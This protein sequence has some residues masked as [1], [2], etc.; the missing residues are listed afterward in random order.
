MPL[1][2][3][4]GFPTPTTKNTINE[5]AVTYGIRDFLL[6]LNLL[7]QYPQI[8]T[9]VNGSPK[10][11][12]PVLDTV[13]G[14]GNVLI[15]IGL[16][17]ETNGIV[18]KDLNVIYN[19]FQNDSNF[20]DNLEEI[21]Y[22]PAISNPDFTGAIWPTNS[23]YPT[24]ANPDVEQ[25]GIKGKTESAQYRKDNV[26]KNLYLDSANQIDMADFI[27]LYPLDVSQQLTNYVDTFGGL[28]QGGTTGDQA[29]NVIGSVLN[30]QGVGLGPGGSVI[31]NFDF[32][33]SL[34][35]RVLGAAGFV[36]DTKLGN[37]G[38]QQLSLALAN[39][40]AFNVQ[41]EILGALNIQ[42]NIFSLIKGDGFAGF[43]PNYKITIPKSTGGQILNGITRVLG[44]QIPR[45]YLDDDGS[46]FQSE[47]GDAANIDRANSMI[48]NTGKGQVKALVSNVIANS[49][50]N[51]T[52]N[53]FRSGYAPAYKNNK[54][55]DAI[56]NEDTKVYA[57]YNAGNVNKILGNAGDVIPELNY[58]REAL[59]MNSGFE[60]PDDLFLSTGILINPGYDNRNVNSV[61]FS[62]SSDKGGTVNRL[63]NTSLLGFPNSIPVETNFIGDRKSLL[64]K[65]QKLF[66]SKGMKTL[67]SVK[68]E[69]GYD[70][71]QTQ[72]ANNDGISKGSAVISKQR[73]DLENGVVNSTAADAY[74]NF[75]R[76]W[77][78]IER[79]DSISRLIRNKPLYKDPEA[80]YRFQTKNSVLDGPFVKIAPY[81]NDS[82]ADPK[83]YMFSI[84]NLAWSDNIDDLPPCEQGPGDLIS[85]QRGRVMWFPPYDIQISESNSV[86]WEET[87]FI[88]RGEPIYTY[89]NTKRTGQL[90]FKV[91]VDHPS[92]YN[93]FRGKSIDTGSPDDNYIAS[94]FAGCIDIDK[95]WADKLLKKED[96]D[97]IE[98]E[99]IITPQ[100]R[101]EPPDPDTP[102]TMRIYFPNDI[103]DYVADYEDAKCSDGSNVDYQQN[104]DGFGCGLSAYTADVTQQDVNGNTK[105]WPDRFDYGLNAGRIST[106]DVGTVV[107]GL[108][109]FGYNDPAYGNNM[110]DFLK[111]Y[112]WAVVN[113][114]GYASPQG[115]PSSNTKL[116]DLRAKTLRDILIDQWGTQLGVTK[117]KLEKRF[118]TL[119][120][121]A[122]TK[123]DVPDCPVES[124]ANPNPPVDIL[125]CKLARRVEISVTFDANLKAEYIKALEPLP[126]LTTYQNYRV[127]GEIRNKFYTECDYFEKLVGDDKKFIFDSIREKIRYFHPAF[128]SMTPEGLN[129]RLTFLLQCTRQGPTLEDVGANN[130]AFGRPP[131]CI[132]RIGDFYHTKIVIDSV[133]IS[134]EPLIWDLN[135]EGIGVQPML[136]NVDMSFSFIGGSSLMGPINKLQNALSFNYFANTHV[137]D[138][139]ADYIAKKPTVTVGGAEGTFEQAL[140]PGGTPTTF[141]DNATPYTT[142]DEYKIV[143]GVSYAQ[144]VKNLNNKLTRELVNENELANSQVKQE[145]V[146][147]SGPVN[148]PPPPP[149]PPPSGDTE[150]DIKVIKAFSIDKYLKI[151][152]TETEDLNLDFI[153][154]FR[155]VMNTKV[156]L[157]KTYK[158]NFYIQN[159][160]TKEKKLIDTIRVRRND[161][162]G[163]ESIIFELGQRSVTVGLQ[164]NKTSFSFS[165]EVNIQGDEPLVSFIKTAYAG[166]DSSLIIEWETGAR[167]MVNF[168]RTVA[169]SS[170]AN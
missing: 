72:T 159:F 61:L 39:N 135:P 43:R 90:S 50:V 139:R 83:K 88:G 67:V 156:L 127:K 111:K 164:D 42:E 25:Y 33:S 114:Q 18:W 118:I 65:T 87:N 91:I 110:V 31:P 153:F 85:G 138:P 53:P 49:S 5:I 29:I 84:E 27:G 129:S 93:S 165:G 170:F 8:A 54:G 95:R 63:P 64:V 140:T 128:H 12:E 10:I 14:T 169:K 146:A 150:N 6:N 107:D 86:N 105:S 34:V 48:L 98:K 121:K 101:Q 134:Y 24:G 56:P 7:P 76:S 51:L 115:N 23:Q 104:C 152:E 120:G 44:F 137:Y 106:E 22:I 77:T 99:T 59:T 125:P 38:A 117:D 149:P 116:A 89:N 26:I 78:T 132:L 155:P 97:R 16:P 70:S 113:F 3:N 166:K 13:V 41:Q 112:P 122:L 60:S 154:E 71:N 143:D 141:V 75:C 45:S 1:F 28:N 35:G 147:N 151:D 161:T 40:A 124:R 157:T 30:G 69:M 4:T 162:P 74:N 163:V 108:T 46:I 79:Y 9:N 144:Y 130:L 131:I 55:E 80:P 68:G 96:I 20:S 81:S 47:N 142:P 73:Y 17:L 109:S 167:P 32:K 158:G 52:T 133:N 123:S 37:V 148:V 102:G 119:K 92:Y 21:N 36:K 160:E 82:V 126:D 145:E 168:N 2:Y 94:F 57:Y 103:K 136:A 15:P 66:N 100:I 11:G 19:T 58:N 62:W